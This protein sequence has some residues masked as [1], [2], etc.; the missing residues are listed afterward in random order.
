M[1]AYQREAER[2][3]QWCV[4][5]KGKPLSSM[6]VED[7]IEYREF[8]VSLADV[9]APWHWQ[10]Q[11]S[12]WIGAK[13][14]PRS[15]PNWRPFEGR[16]SQKSIERSL[17]IVRSMFEWL[18]SQAYLSGNPWRP[19]QLQLSSHERFKHTASSIAVR[20]LALAK[21]EWDGLLELASTLAGSERCARAK[22]VVRLAGQAG[23]RRDELAHVS[24]GS[25]KPLVTKDPNTGE[26][27]KRYLL[28]IR[29]K[30][31]VERMIPMT[32]ELDHCLRA[33]L[34]LRGL[35][36]LPEHCP[37]ATPLI[38]ALTTEQRPDSRLS[39]GRIYAIVK[40]LIQVGAAELERQGRA[41]QAEHM[42]S[43]AHACLAPHLWN[44]GGREELAGGGAGVDGT[45]RRQHDNG[46]LFA[47]QGSAVR[48][49]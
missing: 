16:M 2:G 23:L 8:L 11:R 21:E 29:G 4:Y 18:V 5:E 35:P 46:V 6:T 44:R 17:T 26:E 3:L 10:V 31:G 20:D 13:S 12:D 14:H 28:E 47:T 45:F 39:A 22:V 49:S 15:S 27:R 1:R 41:E 48:A 19:V 40:R 24:T 33:Y 25:L 36:S 37:P 42:R 38:A 9:T 34:Q 32:V 30:G 43:L 7:C